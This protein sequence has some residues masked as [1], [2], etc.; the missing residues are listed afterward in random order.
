MKAIYR[1]IISLGTKDSA[2]QVLELEKS[3]LNMSKDGRPMAAYLNE[4]YEISLN[5]LCSATRKRSHGSV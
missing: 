3:M 1:N 4:M 5:Y 2:E